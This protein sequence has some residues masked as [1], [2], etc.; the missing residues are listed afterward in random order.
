MLSITLIFW[1]SHAQ[2][3]EVY[4]VCPKSLFVVS[5]YKNSLQWKFENSQWT[6]MAKQLQLSAAISSSS[7]FSLLYEH[8]FRPTIL[9]MDFYDICEMF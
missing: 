7:S 3:S 8:S 2:S 6:E 1:W 4:T 5:I 9:S